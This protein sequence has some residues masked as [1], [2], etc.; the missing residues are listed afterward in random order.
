[1]RISVD[2]TDPGYNACAIQCTVKLN[3]EK[4]NYV[5]TADTIMGYVIAH[6]QPFENDSD[7]KTVRVKLKGKVEIF[8]NEHCE[9]IGGV[10]QW[11]KE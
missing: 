5:V 9:I 7:G 8:T 4:N 6:K 3:G 10:L 2:K 11:A 1:M